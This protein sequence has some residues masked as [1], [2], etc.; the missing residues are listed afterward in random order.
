MYVPTAYPEEFVRLPELAKSAPE[1][2]EEMEAPS[3]GLPSEATYRVMLACPKKGMLL[4]EIRM[5]AVRRKS[6]VEMFAEPGV[7]PFANA[8][9]RIDPT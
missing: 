8:E 9:T 7:N 6:T 4:L 5:L 3:T 1:D 2:G